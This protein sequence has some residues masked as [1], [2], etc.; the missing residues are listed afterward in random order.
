MGLVLV[1]S[2]LAAWK[3]IQHL[4]QYQSAF[5]PF[6]WSLYRHKY[7]SQRVFSSSLTLFRSL[8]GAICIQN[9]PFDTRDLT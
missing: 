9:S 6:P 7:Q 8:S 4:Q 2:D 5:R 3:S 1:N